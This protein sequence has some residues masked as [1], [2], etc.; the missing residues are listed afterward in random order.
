MKDTIIAALSVSMSVAFVCAM[1]WLIGYS[2]PDI[3]IWPLLALRTIL[4]TSMSII[5]PGIGLAIAALALF[6]IASFAWGLV[7]TIAE[8]ARGGTD[9]S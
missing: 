6:V 2:W 5:L 9:K 3:L 4:S 8:R 1:G 7:Q